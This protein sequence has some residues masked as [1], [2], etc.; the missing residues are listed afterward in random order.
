MVASRPGRACGGATS[1]PSVTGL[2]GIVGLREWY[3]VMPPHPTAY[4][5]P[6]HSARVGGGTRPRCNDDGAVPFP[7]PA[8]DCGQKK[9]PAEAGAWD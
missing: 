1:A 3:R 6:A 4:A 2:N 5:A 9:T 7:T 8:T